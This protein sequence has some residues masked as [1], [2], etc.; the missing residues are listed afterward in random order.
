MKNKLFLEVIIMK[1][2]YNL[3]KI[4]FAFIAGFS[5]SI[6]IIA[7]YWLAYV[8]VIVSIA[9]LVTA[10]LVEKYNSSIQNYC[11]E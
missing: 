5:L 10:I 1:F 8:A 11:E 3:A 4:L 7:G 6:A 9:G 2:E